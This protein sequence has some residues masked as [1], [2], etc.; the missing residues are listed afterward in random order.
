MS[1]KFF[2]F[3]LAELHLYSYEYYCN[4]IPNSVIIVE[5]HIFKNFPRTINSRVTC[6][7][8]PIITIY[9]RQTVL[10]KNNEVISRRIR[11]VMLE[12]TLM[13]NIW[14]YFGLYIVVPLW[15]LMLTITS[16]NIHMYRAIFFYHEPIFGNINCICYTFFNV[17]SQ[18]SFYI[19]R[20]LQLNQLSGF[21]WKHMILIIIHF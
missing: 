17:F 7:T 20:S 19:F 2:I 4:F 18:I 10:E 6:A 8:R 14:Q 3:L 5:C 13:N 15:W 21:K 1:S 12:W 9:K 11:R 16:R